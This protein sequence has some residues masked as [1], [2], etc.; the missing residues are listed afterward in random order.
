MLAI[1]ALFYAVGEMTAASALFSVRYPTVDLLDQE[2]K[3]VRTIDRGVPDH[4][5]FHG[6][7]SSGP[8]ITAT[9]GGGSAPKGQPG[10]TWHIKGDKAEILATSPMVFTL[11][12]GYHMRIQDRDADGSEVVELGDETLGHLPY[13]ARYVGALYDSFAKGPQAGYPDWDWAVKRHALLAALEESS[14]KGVRVSIP[15]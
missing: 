13:T 8:I 5:S 14:T 11:A 10:I 4:V 9:C 1:D 7:L 15:L 2:G 12:E 6:T 3:V